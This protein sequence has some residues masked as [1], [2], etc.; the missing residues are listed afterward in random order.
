MNS[1]LALTQIK[2]FIEKLEIASDNINPK[3]ALQKSLY[4]Q[5][6]A[7]LVWNHL[8]NTDLIDESS[9]YFLRESISDSS[10]AYFLTS[11]GVY[12]QSRTCLRS[13][14]ENAMR[15]IV[16]NSGAD[17]SKFNTI[18]ELFKFAKTTSEIKSF[19]DSCDYLYS[20]YKNLCLTVHSAAIEY[21][22]LVVP[23]SEIIDINIDEANGN[24]VLIKNVYSKINEVMYVSY[25]SVLPRAYYKHADAILDALPSS[26]KSEVAANI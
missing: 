12:K 8:S 9:E 15:S 26:L 5:F 3:S 10:V 24:F 18:P 25:G 13:A 14:I 4:K 11:I 22:S 1:E 20:Q 21:M 7:L 23:F 2:Q 6:H 16:A 19:T 17:V